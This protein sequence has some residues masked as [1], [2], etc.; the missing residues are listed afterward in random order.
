M[1]IIHPY[2]PVLPAS[3]ARLQVYLAQCSGML[4]EA[5]LEALAGTL[6]SFPAF[7]SPTAGDVGLAKKMLVE[8]ELNDDAPRTQASHVVHLQTIMLLL[9]EADV[10]PAGCADTQK[11]SLLGRAVGT[12]WALR[13]HLSRTDKNVDPDPNSD[14]NV[15]IRLWWSLVVLDRWNAISMGTPTMTHRQAAVV[16]SGVPE[17]LGQ[18][19]W[20]LLRASPLQFCLVFVYGIT[21]SSAES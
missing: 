16:Q 18:V 7:T 17:I 12:A 6:H 13:L 4:R 2:V 14:V 8:W 9:I 15:R 3:K 20:L 10:R 1:T 21:D 11:E 5:F 19:P